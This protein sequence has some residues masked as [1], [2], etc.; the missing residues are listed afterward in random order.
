MKNSMTNDRLG[1]F[2]KKKIKNI[3]KKKI[4]PSEEVE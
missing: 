1:V 2:K 3:I 4:I